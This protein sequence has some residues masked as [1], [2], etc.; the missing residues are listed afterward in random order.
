M[1]KIK[2]LTIAVIGLLIINVGIIGFLLC[3]KPPHPPGGRP[4]ISQE[5]PKKI[6]IERLHFDKEQIVSYEKL[7]AEHQEMMKSMN[8]SIRRAKNDLY[9]TLSFEN[10]TRKDSLINHLNDLQEKVEQINYEHFVALKNL[11]KTNQLGDYND[12][13]KELARFFAVN[14][15]APPPSR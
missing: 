13:T 1:S 8:D 9:R 7:I 10:F 6:I 4:P 3:R 2:L 14:K 12:L 15:K 11:C 5:G